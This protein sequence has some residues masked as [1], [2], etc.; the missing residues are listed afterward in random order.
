MRARRRAMSPSVFSEV[1]MKRYLTSAAALLGL[2]IAGPAF[3]Q[4]TTQQPGAAAPKKMS[5]AQCEIVWARINVAKAPTVSATQA[6]SALGSSNFKTA[7]ANNDGMVSH[8]EFLVACNEGKVSDT[9]TGSRA[10]QGTDPD[11]SKK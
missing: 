4:T 9:G 5:D 10:L 1:R 2:V 8:A 3:P 7:D 11:Q 6:E